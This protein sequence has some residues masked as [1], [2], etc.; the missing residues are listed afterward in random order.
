MS[1]AKKV[2]VLLVEDE[3]ILSDMYS[4]KFER[5]GME[6]VVVDNGGGVLSQAQSTKPDIILLDIILPQEDG[7]SVL[8]ELKSA[9]ETKK[10]KVLMLTNLGQDED[11]KKGKDLGADGYLVKSNLTPAQVVDKIKEVLKIKN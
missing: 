5:E 10:I 9:A 7:F 1:N 11:I 4:L 6:V 2:K 3:K 8:K